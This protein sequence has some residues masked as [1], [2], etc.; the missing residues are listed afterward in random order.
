MEEKCKKIPESN[1]AWAENHLHSK[2]RKF[3]RRNQ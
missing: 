2:W 3:H 1:A